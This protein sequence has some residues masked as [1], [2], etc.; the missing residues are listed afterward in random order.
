M[1]EGAAET[2]KIAAGA[3]SRSDDSLSAA[4]WREAWRARFARTAIPGL[5]GVRA[6]A[7][8]LVIA[9]H[10]G[11]EQVNAAFGVMMFFVLSGF[12]ITWLMLKEIEGSGTVSLREFYR[13]RMLRIFP[14]FYAFWLFVVGLYFVRGHELRTGEA[15]SAFF[16]YSNYYLTFGSTE[17]S[18]F[19][20]TWSLSIEEQFYLLW[21]LLF[22][23]GIRNPV[24]LAK[25]LVVAI[26]T[27]WLWRTV[28]YTVLDLDAKYIY[29]AFDTRFDHLAVGCLAALLLKQGMLEEIMRPLTQ[30]AWYPAVVLAALLAAQALHESEAFTYIVGYALEPLLVAIFILQLVWFS[31]KGVWRIFEHPVTRYLGRISYALY[32]WQQ[33]TLY[34]AK[35]LTPGLPVLLQFLFALGV[36][37]AFATASY[38]IIEK[39]FLKLKHRH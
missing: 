38:F 4:S 21:P 6:L 29:R 31:D 2:T 25:I 35:R 1:T 36:T 5:D 32:L 8:L 27:C 10:F 16:Y 19:G 15:V 28:A 26:I 13:R 3:S 20:H 7:V 12:L 24:R 39:P 30:R 14:A 11:F 9:G 17:D 18:P 34:T 22:L 37:V 33:L 23:M